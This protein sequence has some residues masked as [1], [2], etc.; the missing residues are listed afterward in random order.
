MEN[1]PNGHVVNCPVC[2]KEINIRDLHAV[3]AH[4]I[5]NQRTGNRVCVSVS[6][7]AIPQVTYSFFGKMIHRKK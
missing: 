7:P 3:K 1:S 6:D 2:G 4:G 5:L